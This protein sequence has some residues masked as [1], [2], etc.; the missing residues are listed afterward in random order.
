MSFTGVVL[1]GSCAAASLFLSAVL[2]F[3]QRRRPMNLWLSIVS[4]MCGLWTAGVASFLAYPESR[5][6]PVFMAVYYMAAMLIPFSL[7]FFLHYFPRKIGISKFEIGVSVVVALLVLGLVATPGALIREVS[8]DGGLSVSL[9]ESGYALYVGVFI[10]LSVSSLFVALANVR[11][12]RRRGEAVLARQAHKIIIVALVAMVGGTTF[13][14]FLPMAGVYTLI[15][16]GPPFAAAFS[17][18][19]FYVI[20]RQGLFD[21]RAALARTVAYTLMLTV[22]VSVY[23][24]VLFGSSG[25]L[26]P[27]SDVGSVQLLFYIVMAL[28]LLASARP[29]RS[30]LDRFTHNVFY[31]SD[32]DSQKTMQEIAE[33][34]ASEID[35]RQLVRR[36]VDALCQSIQPEYG[37][38]FVF[39]S[40]GKT[41]HYGK[42]LSGKRMHAIYRRQMRVVETRLNELPH[43]MRSNNATSVDERR[44][45]DRMNAEVVVQLTLRGEHLGVLFLGG[46]K[47]GEQ[48]N[49]DDMQLLRLAGDELALAIQNALRFEE[50][51]KFNHRLR[52]EISRA[53]RDLRRSNR[54]LHQ[55]DEVKNDF[56]SIASHQLRTPLTSIKGYLSMVL[57][58]DA[59]EVT[60]LQRQLLE[61]SFTSSQ[62]MVALIEDFLNLSRMQTGRF[63]IDRRPINITDVVRE[64]VDNLRSTAETRALQLQ[65]IV[66]KDIPEKILADE[67]KIRQV[68]MNLIDN[69]IYY[70]RPEKRIQVR[71]SRDGAN[72]RYVVHDKGIGVPKAEQPRLFTRFYRA[73]NARQQRP[74]GTGVGLYLAKRVVDEHGGDMIFRSVEGEGSTFG[75]TLP[76]ELPEKTTS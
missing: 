69:A 74:D 37:S 21:V 10:F 49:N 40:S 26:F 60:P 65:L 15:W 70:S 16:A 4:L 66:G 45:L 11:D 32:Y 62:R 35:L 29:L 8:Y 75:F 12:V 18:Y 53:T 22:T 67:G 41:Y 47:S 36:S 33:I 43:L 51:Q 34:T 27:H 68:V 55:L 38:F 57:D 31:R 64:E 28:I 17:M 72:I 58:G 9:N 71:I 1:L 42:N 3:S 54:E 56:L 14:L 25:L 50:I 24:A 6:A 63:S 19:I 59:G 23:A 73:R 76:I 44:M 61:E 48:Y 2:L 13:N 5:Q 20:I 52:N 30:L 7:F 46:R 39:S